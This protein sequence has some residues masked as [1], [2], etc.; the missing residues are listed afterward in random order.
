MHIDLIKLHGIQLLHTEFQ[1]TINSVEEI[2]NGYLVTAEVLRLDDNDEDLKDEK[3]VFVGYK[4]HEEWEE[5]WS[6]YSKLCKMC[7]GTGKIQHEAHTH[8]CWN[9]NGT[10][11]R[12][13]FWNK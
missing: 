11:K 6:K 7:A 13:K 9:C 1:C 5:L 3:K 10:G 2:E 8:R 4:E 12:L